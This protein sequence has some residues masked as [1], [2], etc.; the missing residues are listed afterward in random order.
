MP[1]AE[2]ATVIPCEIS[3]SRGNLILIIMFIQKYD[4]RSQNWLV[5]WR[6][7]IPKQIWDLQHTG[8]SCMHLLPTLLFAGQFWGQAIYLEDNSSSAP[9]SQQHTTPGQCCPLSPADS[10]GNLLCYQ[11]AQFPPQPFCWLSVGISQIYATIL[12]AGSATR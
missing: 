2:D 3:Y 12:C 11:Q 9:E 8:N 10:L 4:L 6:D 7:D 1:K 5:S